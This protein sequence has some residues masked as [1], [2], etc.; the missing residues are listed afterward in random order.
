MKKN[1]LSVIFFLLCIIS[2]LIY[3][4]FNNLNINY[5]YI[6]DSR[7]YYINSFKYEKYLYDSVNYKNIKNNIINNDFK[8]IKNKNVYL[9]QLISNSDVIILN[10]NNFEFNNKC[11]KNKRII[12]E[13]DEIN[14]NNLE[15]LVDLINKISNA[16]LY[17]LG[18]YCIDGVYE[19]EYKSSK[20]VY[21]SHKN[22]EN[23]DKIIRKTMYN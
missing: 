22:V 3:K 16:K 8:V 4:K 7:T 21:I 13:Y 17:V 12:S 2:F 9:N 18:N 5:L 23:I 20:Y 10:A 1:K 11:K 19:Q 15:E 14:Y 6:G